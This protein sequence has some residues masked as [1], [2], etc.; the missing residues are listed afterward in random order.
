MGVT[1]SG[2][3]SAGPQPGICGGNCEDCG[4][5]EDEVGEELTLR[6]ISQAPVQSSAKYTPVHRRC[7]RKTSWADVAPRLAGEQRVFVLQKEG[8]IVR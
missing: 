1:T 3:T 7:S 8:F 4:N 6:V 2:H 5:G